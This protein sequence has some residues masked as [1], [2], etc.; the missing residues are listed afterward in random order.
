MSPAHP[1]A[2]RILVIDD[3]VKFCSIVE[4]FL[5][6]RGYDVTTASTS[7]DA[8]AQME[9]FHPDVILMDIVMPGLSGLELLKLARERAFPPR[10]IM[11]TAT[12]E[13][14]AVEQAMC[15]G[16][17]A[18]MCKPV[19]LNALERVISGIWP[20]AKDEGAPP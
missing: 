10:V 7:R 14:Q 12:A 20:A 9:R 8:L 4:T 5:V 13:G 16:A 3:E 18:Y 15:D 6:G 2:Q 19:D 17:E 1:R 11:V